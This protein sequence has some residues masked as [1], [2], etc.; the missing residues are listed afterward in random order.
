M[1]FNKFS[2]LDVL[3]YR[4]E[5]IKERISSLAPN[6]ILNASEEDL[7]TSFKDEYTFDTPE[8]DESG[9]HIDYGEQDIDVSQ[10]PMRMFVDP[11]QP[12]YVAGTRITFIIPFSGD[13]KLF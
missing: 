2:I 7:I 4:D 13:A 11:S 3:P 12:F 9:I 1:L 8:L 6:L 5:Q 10:D